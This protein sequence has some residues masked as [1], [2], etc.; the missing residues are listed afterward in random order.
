MQPQ[1]HL[2][3]VHDYLLVSRGA[4]RTFGVMA[5]MWPAAEVFSLLY[6]EQVARGLLGPRPVR[7]SR[8]Q[9][10][11]ARQRHFRYLLPLLP[12]AAVTLRLSEFDLVLSSSSAFAHGVRARRDALHVCYCHSPFRYAWH[13]RSRALLEVARPARP[14]LATTLSGIQR[15]DRHAAQRVDHYIA[16][17]RLTQE[18]I[19]S[20]WEREATVI[21]PPVEVERFAVGE[22]HDY[23]LTVGEIV[24]HKRVDAALEA[25]KRAGRRIKI[26]G[27]GPELASLH[28][29]YAGSAEFLGRVA[30]EELARLYASA[31]A[32]IVPNVEEFGIAAVEAQAAGRPVL[33]VN[34]GGVRETVVDGRTGVLVDEGVDALAEAMAHVDFSRFDP[35]E[36]SHHARN[37]SRDCF[38]A[39][40]EAEL[41][42]LVAAHSL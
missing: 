3:L 38:K 42:R 24:A 7:A 27:T 10:L 29:K 13:E 35:S 4:E 20:Y 33:A 28:A 39:R 14:L 26:V 22:P 30:D 23:F 11:R 37:F 17:S 15:W 8:L 2:A 9:H 21:H 18:R 32:L 41:N 1:R 40:L 16:N 6:D 31:S 25:A 19:W 34:A 36:I 12:A 5:G